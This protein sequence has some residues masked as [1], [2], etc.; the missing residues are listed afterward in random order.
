M[1]FRSN[2][3]NYPLQRIW[4]GAVTAPSSSA[5]RHKGANNPHRKMAASTSGRQ[6]TASARLG[7]LHQPSG[8]AAGKEKLPNVSLGAGRAVGRS[9]FSAT[10]AGGQP[11]AG[12]GGSAASDPG[13][14]PFQGALLKSMHPSGDAPQ[15]TTWGASSSCTCT[16]A[17]SGFLTL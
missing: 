10:I 5:C 1:L 17:H 6:T 13:L 9:Q 3:H 7:C 8:P 4:P 15:Q 11:K 2:L 16:S 12:P 14:R